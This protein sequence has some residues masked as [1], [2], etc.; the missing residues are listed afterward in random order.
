MTRT[1]LFLEEDLMTM[2]RKLAE[3]QK[4]TISE[5]VRQAVRDRYLGDLEKRREAMEAIVG[6]RADDPDTRDSTEIIRELRR[7]DRLERLYG[8]SDDN[9]G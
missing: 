1:Q 4:T 5:L 9:S 3:T 6:M 7:S 2:L 8:N